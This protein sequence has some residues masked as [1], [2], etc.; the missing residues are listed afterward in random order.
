MRFYNPLALSDP[1]NPARPADVD[2]KFISMSSASTFAS[3]RKGHEI[4]VAKK[5]HEEIVRLVQRLF[6]WPQPTPPQVVV[7]AGVEHGT[8]CSRI[9]AYTAKVL[10][11]QLEGSVCLVDA[12]FRPTIHG[13]FRIA[14]PSTEPDEKWLS[15]PLQRPVESQGNANLWFLP[16]P[17]GKEEWQTALSLDRFR[18]RI[19]ELRKDFSYVLID[20]PPVNAYSDT[21][22]LGRMADG[23]VM[24]VEANRTRREL[25]LNAKETLEAA[26]VRLFGIVLNKRTFP[27]PG[28]LY[29]RL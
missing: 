17:P 15:A 10:A 23:L 28:A 12:N 19:E 20:A 16:C 14:E 22:L 1:A 6:L 2:N 8:G 4:D 3:A 24:V 18:E 11:D 13:H 26:G 21:T 29:R 27:I 25:T 7:F 5:T 9:C